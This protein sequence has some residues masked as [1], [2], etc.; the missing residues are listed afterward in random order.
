MEI[1]KH[2][3]SKLKINVLLIVLQVVWHIDNIYFWKKNCVFGLIREYTSKT[4]LK[5]MVR[6]ASQY[7]LEFKHHII[8]GRSVECRM[9]FG[10]QDSWNLHM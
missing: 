2:R 1:N 8:F 3:K 10:G 7:N 5:F 6:T 9:A 4:F